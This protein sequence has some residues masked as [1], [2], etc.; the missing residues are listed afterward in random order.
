MES[1]TELT[2]PALLSAAPSPGTRAAAPL[3]LVFASSEAAP[4]AKTGG[5]GDVVGALPRALAE[6]GHQCLV[7]LPLF[8]CARA[9]GLPLEPTEHEFTI[10]IGARPVPGRLCRSRLPGSAVTVLLVEQPELFERDDPA[11]GHSLYQYRLPNGR[12]KDY[13]DNCQRFIFFSRAVLEA[14]A[15]IDFWPDVLHCNDWQ[16]GLIPAYVRELYGQADPRFEPLHTLYT[17][18]NLA[19]QGAFWHWDMLLTGLDWSLFNWQQLEFYGHLNL[20]KAGIVF[21]DMVSTVSARYAQEIQTAEQGCGLEGVLRH[22]SDKLVGINNGIDYRDWNPATDPHLAANYRSETVAEGKATCK[23]AL[24]ARLKLPV[25]ADVPVLGMISRLVEQKGLDL[26]AMAAPQLLE[27]DIQLVVLGTGDAVYHELLRRL[28]V[29]SPRKV[30]AVLAFDEALAHQIEAGADIFLMPSR[31]EPA[32]LNQ[33]YSLKYGT[34][35][36][37]R[38]TGGLSDTVTDCNPQTLAAGVATGFLFKDYTATAFLQAVRRALQAYRDPDG[39]RRL[40][41]TGMSQDWSWQ[42]RAVEY[43]ELYHRMTMKVGLAR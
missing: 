4:F 36:V 28:M 20:M 8:R 21:A 2:Q 26:L 16:T 22:Y 37:V 24:Q 23:A 31:F 10:P 25:R 13:I 35:P 42:R 6:R 41:R 15:L 9:A 11:L 17:I 19:Y 43:E 34:V 40:Q 18:H 12:M 30:A 33:L 38:N 1:R 3:K 39:W 5:L 7:M 32:G 29:R 14:L 27:E